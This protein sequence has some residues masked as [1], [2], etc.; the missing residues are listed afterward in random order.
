[1]D[2]KVER[3]LTQ[4][5][6]V[7][8]KSE[9]RQCS[10]VAL[11]RLCYKKIIIMTTMMMMMI[12]SRHAVTAKVPVVRTNGQT[13]NPVDGRQVHTPATQVPPNHG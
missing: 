6:A 7:S 5:V 9:V 8:S 13:I 2:L 10:S 3:R 1:M 4:Q 12:Q 11:C